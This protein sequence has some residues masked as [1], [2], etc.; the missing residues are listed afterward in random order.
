[1]EHTAPARS[2]AYYAT[3]T[4]VRGVFATAVV[5]AFYAVPGAIELAAEALMAGLGH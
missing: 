1:M 3:R 4:T 5:A 2:R